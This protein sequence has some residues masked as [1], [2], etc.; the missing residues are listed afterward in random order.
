[1]KTLKPISILD[2]D[3]TNE[4]LFDLLYDLF[5]SHE[6]YVSAG[7]GKSTNDV[8]VYFCVNEKHLVLCTQTENRETMKLFRSPDDIVRVYGDSESAVDYAQR[9]VSI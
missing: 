6:G 2:N 1:M 3:S 7:F 8:F 9:M 5:E 4:I